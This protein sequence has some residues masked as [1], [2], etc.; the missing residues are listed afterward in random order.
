MSDENWQRARLIPVSGIG[1]Q[2]EKERRATSALLAVLGAVKEFGRAV[3]TQLGAPAGTVSTFCEVPFELP[4]GQKVRVDG[5]IRVQRGNRVWTVLVEVK[6]GTNELTR[7]QVE[8]YLEVVREHGFNGL[9]TISNEI[10]TVVG[11]HPVGVGRKFRRVPLFHISWTRILTLAQMVKEHQGVSDPDQAWILGEL[12]RYLEYEGSGA[13]AFEDM[14]PHW[15]AVRSAVKDGTLR[16]ADKGVEEIAARW[17]Q[18]VQFLCLGLAARLGQ[19][20]RPALSRKELNDPDART[21][22][23]VHELVHTG[24]LSGGIRIPNTVGPIHLEANLR[25][26]TAEASIELTAPELKQSSPRITW[27]LRQLR[28]A[29][30]ELRIDVAFE[31][32]RSTSSDLLARVTGN[33]KRLL[34]ERDHAPR[35]FTLTLSG[36][37]GAKRKAGKGSFISDVSAL[38]DH[39]YRDVVQ[40]LE[41][42]TPPAPQLRPAASAPNQPEEDTSPTEELPALTDGEEHHE[43]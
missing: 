3:L 31:R 18:L 15:V 12:I 10:V 23:L 41:A 2:E 35:S 22:A 4:D 13:V 7:Q 33:P 11:H 14:G 5:L 20:V 32:K 1:G 8:S 24:T 34:T 29:P 39:F 19:E 28:N 17:D 27:L 9:L 43:A 26:M 16:L 30:P 21:A 6:T 40:D 25:R 38:L 42:W 36:V 37:V